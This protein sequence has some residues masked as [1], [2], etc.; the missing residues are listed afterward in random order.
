LHNEEDHPNKPM[1]TIVVFSLHIEVCKINYSSPRISYWLK[2]AVAPAVDSAAAVA[3]RLT[4]AAVGLISTGG[5]F[6]H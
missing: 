5:I 4:A 6:R 1:F 3:V 2:R